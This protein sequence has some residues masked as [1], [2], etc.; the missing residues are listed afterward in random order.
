VATHRAKSWN[1]LTDLLYAHSWHAH[2]GRFRSSFAFRGM[3][4]AGADLTTTLARLG[5]HFEKQEGHLLRNFRKYAH[6]DAVPGDSIW[7]WLSLAQHHG[8]PTRLLDWTYSPFVAL[9][10]ATQDVER[11]DLD[12]VI[13]CI[14]YSR[15]H[16]LL[17]QR[18]RKALKDEQADVFTAEILAPVAS[19]LPKF[20]QLAPRGKPFVLFLEPPSLDDRIVNQFALFSMMSSPS[21]HMNDW[22]PRH[23]SLCRK[24]IIPAKL[25]WEVRDKLDQANIT[26]RVLF[27]GLDGLSRWLQRYYS[28][29]DAT[30]RM[31]TP[32]NQPLRR[33]KRADDRV[34]PAPAS[35]ASAHGGNGTFAAASGGRKR[36]RRSSRSARKGRGK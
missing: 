27:P 10:F 23:G 9:H 11:F 21:A 20:D 13:W 16:R 36:R 34:T 29:R 14:D 2:L 18:L 26:E 7:N 6:R 5:G 35:A 25:K 12:G 19:T 17:P 15:T 3:Q 33:A 31:E 32:D 30:S 24:I 4:R 8:L 22:L 28:P 1:D